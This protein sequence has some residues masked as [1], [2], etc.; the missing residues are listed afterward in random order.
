MRG[1]DEWFTGED[2][3]MVA[4]V[5]EGTRGGGG[6]P[7]RTPCAALLRAPH[8]ERGE[9]GGERGSAGG[10]SRSAGRRRSGERRSRTARARAGMARVA[11]SGPVGSDVAVHVGGQ[12][13]SE[14]FWTSSDTLE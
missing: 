10:G 7:T 6:P 2:E 8:G 12:R 3:S 5:G 11:A 9:E 4:G 1:I 14:V 13:W